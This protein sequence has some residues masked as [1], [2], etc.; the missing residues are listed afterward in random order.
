MGVF[1]CQ[2]ICRWMKRGITGSSP[3]SLLLE[4]PSCRF[5]PGGSPEGRAT[6]AWLR[7]R[8]RQARAAEP[9]ARAEQLLRLLAPLP[10]RRLPASPEAL[11]P[12]HPVSPLQPPEV[13]AMVGPAVCRDSHE[14]WHECSTNLY[15][16]MLPVASLSPR[17]VAR[18]WEAVRHQTAAGAYY[19]PGLR[20]EQEHAFSQLVVMGTGAC[21]RG[22]GGALGCRERGGSDRRSCRQR[23]GGGRG[24]CKRTL[25]AG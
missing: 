1:A 6:Q 10:L 15:S 11:P 25:E 16:E 22:G 2:L 24:S 13:T 18:A 21:R 3:S 20:R 9:P 17:H 23:V 7:Q 4:K 8:R 12:Y 5:Q 19:C 14:T